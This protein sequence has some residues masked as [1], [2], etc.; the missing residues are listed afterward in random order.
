M[1]RPKKDDARTIIY[2]VRLNENENRM[3]TEASEYASAPRSEVFRTALYDYH[4]TV[5]P[6][7]AEKK[8]D[9]DM[10]VPCGDGMINIRVGAIILKDRRFL[11][12]RN[13]GAEYYYSVGGRIRFGETAEVAVVRE[14]YEE[15]GARLEI[16]HLGFV[17][18]NYFIGDSPSGMGKVYYE[19]AF[20]FYM[21]VPDGFEPLCD[22]FTEDGR[23]EYLEW[24][25]PEEPGTVFPEFFRTDLDIRNTA[26]K[27]LV[28]DDRFYIRKMTAGD[29]GPLYGLLS[30][31]EVMDCLE[32]PF[33]YAQTERFLKTQ[34]L[35][36]SPRILS[37]DDKDHRFIG[38]VIY[39]DYDDESKEIGW[40]L[41]KEKWGQGLASLLTKQLIAMAES[42][43]KATV[44]ECVPEQQ[45]TRRI[46]EKHGYKKV[47]EREGLYIYRRERNA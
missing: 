44:I 40:V 47:A 30:D 4:Q 8:T 42:E 6:E 18:E 21:K 39:H 22:S 3:L 10:S 26:V 12:V 34:G 5:R 15:T 19:L 28:N 38:Y 27:H 36:F 11:M 43:G 16:D 45:A 1:A 23:K 14:V 17:Q 7:H 33:T 35:T 24:V 31:P 13:T 37:V 2:K 41:K 32:P 46:A 9:P 20:F 25:S 29:L